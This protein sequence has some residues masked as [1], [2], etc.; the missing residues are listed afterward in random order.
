[1]VLEIP[2]RKINLGQNIISI[3]GRS[4]S[5]KLSNDLKILNTSFTSRHF[6]YS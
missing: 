2:L 1:M 3:M 6:I 4:I 5:N